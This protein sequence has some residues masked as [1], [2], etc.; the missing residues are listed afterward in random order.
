MFVNSRNLKIIVVLSNRTD[1]I[2]LSAPQ[3]G[4]NVQ[5]MVFN[6]AGERG[7]GEE[8]ILVNPIVYRVSKKTVLFN[9]GCLSFPGIYADVE[10]R[11]ILFSFFVLGIMPT[12]VL[13]LCICSR[14]YLEQPVIG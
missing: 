6:S 3:V 4:I 10:A 14:M 13:C 11:I 12:I 1:G 2:G 5:L 7:E 9:E 8:I